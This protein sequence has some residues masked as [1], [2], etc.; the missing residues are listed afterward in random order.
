MALY[1]GY[2]GFNVTLSAPMTAATKTLATLWDTRQTIE[3]EQFMY[4]SWD[5]DNVL[6]NTSTSLVN[7]V[8]LAKVPC[9]TPVFQMAYDSDLLPGTILCQLRVSQDPTY[10]SQAE[11]SPVTFVPSNSLGDVCHVSAQ[12][13]LEDNA[14]YY[15]SARAGQFGTWSEWSSN[16]SFEIDTLYG[17]GVQYGALADV[18]TYSG[19]D[20]DPLLWYLS[21]DHADAG[22]QITAYGKWLAGAVEVHINGTV[23]SPDSVVT[24]LGTSDEF[25]AD[26]YIS[27]STISTSLAHDEVTFTVPSGYADDVVTTISIGVE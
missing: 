8:S 25:T 13:S 23:V 11:W 6:T 9:T 21:D 24:V 18:V 2:Y 27:E 14:V 12:S 22:D 26:R 20:A 5:T 19:A 15:W 3:V 17:S 7:P 16:E 4:A 1:T 10:T